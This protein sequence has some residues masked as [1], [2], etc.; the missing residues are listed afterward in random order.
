M[1]NHNLLEDEREIPNYS[2]FQSP[3]R[4]HFNLNQVWIDQALSLPRLSTDA[5]R[6]RLH[7]VSIYLQLGFPGGP[8][9]GGEGPCE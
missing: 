6:F 3:L 7:A 8:W 9:L 2:C 5:A 1:T 4:A